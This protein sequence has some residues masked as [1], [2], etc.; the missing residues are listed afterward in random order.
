MI[1]WYSS[2]VS[3]WLAMS[4]GVTSGWARFLGWTLAIRLRSVG[5]SRRNRGKDF[6]AIVA[7][8]NPTARVFRMGHQTK[9]VALFV[10]YAGNIFQRTVG[11]GCRRRPALRI[12]I[13]EQN[14]PVFVQ[15]LD[16]FRIGVITTFAMFD[17]KFEHLAFLNSRSKRSIG[18]LDSH[19]NRLANKLKIDI[20]HQSPGQQTGLAKNLKAVADAE[21]KPPLPSELDDALHNRR[22]ARH[23]AATQVVAV[24]KSAR[25]HQA[26]VVAGEVILVPQGF[27][28]LSQ[29]YLETVK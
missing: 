19:M 9:D 24:G 18:F 26:I 5:A 13:A 8:E 4:S 17:G 29:L 10:A 3:P 15:A 12:D 11:I 16:R 27:D 7:A 2:G 28:L 25:Q 21:N 20:T 23:G 6:S 22:E 14:L 1:F